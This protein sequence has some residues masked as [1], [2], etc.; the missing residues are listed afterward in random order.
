[1]RFAPPRDAILNDQPRSPHHRC[2]SR[3]GWV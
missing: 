3:S 1:M 2:G